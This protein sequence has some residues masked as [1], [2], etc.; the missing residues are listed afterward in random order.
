MSSLDSMLREGAGH[1]QAGNYAAAE[2]LYRKILAARPREATTLYLLG[3]LEYQTDRLE[4]AAQ[5]LH[6]SVKI[7]PDNPDARNS[8]GLVLTEKRRYNDAAIQFRRAL[9]LRPRFPQAK[10][11]LGNVHREQGNLAEAVDAYRGALALDPSYIE[12][13]ENLALTY[14]NLGELEDALSITDKALTLTQGRYMTHYVRGVV[15]REM[16]RYQEALESFEKAHHLSPHSAE[17][18]AGIGACLALQRKWGEAEETCRRALLLDPKSGVAHNYLGVALHESG[19]YAEAIE[20]FRQAAASNQAAIDALVNLGAAYFAVGDK[21]EIQNAI[22]AFEEVLRRQPQHYTAAMNV[23]NIYVQ[24]DRIEDARPWYNRI[25]KSRPQ[26]ANVLSFRSECCLCP[27]IFDSQSQ[28]DDYYHSLLDSLDNQRESG[29]RSDLNTLTRFDIRPHFNLPFLGVNDRIHKEKFAAALTPSFEPYSEPNRNFATGLP[30]VGFIVTER[31]E[32]AFLKSIGAIVNN[33]DSR[34][35]RRTIVCSER[36]EAILRGGFSDPALEY[37][38]LNGNPAIAADQ[39]RDQKFDMLYYFEVGTDWLNY[40]L[41]YCNL[42]PL[43]ATTWGIQV[44]TGIPQMDYYISSSLFEPADAQD[45]YSEKLI[46]LNTML[47]HQFRLPMPSQRLPREAFGIKP[48]A[49]VYLCFQHL[50]KFHPE[51]DAT[52]AAILERDPK[53]EILITTGRQP[54][55]TAKLQARWEKSLGE[56][57]HRIRVFEPQGGDHYSSLILNSDLTLDPPH[58]GGV[59][60]SYDAFSMGKVVVTTPSKYHRGRYTSG[61]YRMMGLDEMVATS[62][63]DYV[64]RAVK[65]AS[66]PDYRRELE[67]QLTQANGVLFENTRATRELEELLVRLIEEGRASP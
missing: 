19:R 65:I 58:F 30:S 26:Y 9:Q 13:M 55:A 34:K 22:D 59:N 17:G 67:S 7:Q 11:N 42:A 37:C 64:D 41:P 3:T 61:C 48:D 52:L 20:S 4:D 49:H 45:H 47:S 12:A 62:T 10:Y 40:Q 39:I 56:N 24:M 54:W 27:L 5:H 6:Q 43:Q 29:F 35:L 25:V 44:T 50:G 31:H 36:G 15:L 51:F 32:K 2:T 21:Q 38:V 16:N 8:L 53:G 18:L 66:E 23:A 1:H 46:L 57:A 60:T 28:L 33:L 63:E 14:R